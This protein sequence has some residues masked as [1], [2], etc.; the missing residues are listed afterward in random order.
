MSIMSL[1]REGAGC[2]LTYKNKALLLERNPD[3]INNDKKRHQLEYPGGKVKEDETYIQCA[4]RE[5]YEETGK[6]LRL[7][8]LQ[9]NNNFVIVKSHTNKGIC[10]FRI[11]MTDDQYNTVDEINTGLKENAIRNRV[12]C[13]SLSVMM[14]ELDKLK[15]NDLPLPLRGFC[16]IMLKE[17]VSKNII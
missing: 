7:N 1:L 8:V 4:I 14:V 16:K 2:L 10:L 15:T 9:F 12:K 6:I 11:E 13:E 3:Y 17:L 5:V